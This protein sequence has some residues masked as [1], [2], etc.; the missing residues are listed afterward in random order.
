MK[1]N[2]DVTLFEMEEKE[3]NVLDKYAEMAKEFG[4]NQ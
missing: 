1:E 2:L 3:Y 4:W